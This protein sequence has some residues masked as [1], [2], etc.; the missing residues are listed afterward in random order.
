MKVSRYHIGKL[1]KKLNRMR[2]HLES[3]QL[4]SFHNLLPK[5]ITKEICRQEE[6]HFR[7]RLLTPVVTVFHMLNAAISRENS[8]QSAW[9]NIGETNQSG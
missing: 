1:R 2:R 5:K 6:Y 4:K 9:H 3:T 8:F 7:Q